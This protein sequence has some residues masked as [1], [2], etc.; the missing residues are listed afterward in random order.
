MDGMADISKILGIIMENPDIIETIKNL[1]SKTD[2][3][4][5]ESCAISKAECTEKENSG[6]TKNEVC[7]DAEA[8]KCSERDTNA[9]KRRKDL[10]CAIKPYVSKERGK[11]IDTMLSVVD[12]IDIV[13]A[14]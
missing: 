14:R 3:K 7:S 12:V 11:A 9:K 4:I 2:E 13:K 1:A 5:P 10:L 6:C 8:P